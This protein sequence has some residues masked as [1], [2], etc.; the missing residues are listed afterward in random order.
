MTEYHDPSNVMN[1]EH[2][3][4][5]IVTPAVYAIVFATLLSGPQSQL[6]RR[7][8][9]SESSIRSWRWPSPAPRQ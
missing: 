7:M 8:S 9:I 4:H 2:A 3:D 1:P 6:L 5:H